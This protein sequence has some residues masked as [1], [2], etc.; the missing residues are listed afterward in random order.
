MLAQGA[1]TIF[2][3]VL[4]QTAREMPLAALLDT[5][6]DPP[7]RPSKHA[8]ELFVAA[9]FGGSVPTRTR[10]AMTQTSSTSQP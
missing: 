10:C 7:V 1:A 6:R 5:L 9:R 4:A 2:S 3:N 8:C